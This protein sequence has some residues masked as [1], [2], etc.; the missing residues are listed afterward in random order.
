MYSF[1]HTNDWEDTHIYVCA[2]SCGSPV[3]VKGLAE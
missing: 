2:E 1:D 3:L